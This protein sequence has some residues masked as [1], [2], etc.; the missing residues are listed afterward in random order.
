M[1]EADK[2]IETD[3]RYRRKTDLPVSMSTDCFIKYILIKGL[4]EHKRISNKMSKK[5]VL[6]VPRST[7]IILPM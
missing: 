2:R 4:I 7:L 1:N 3:G 6:S 5:N